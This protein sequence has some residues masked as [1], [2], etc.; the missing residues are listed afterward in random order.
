MTATLTT[1]SKYSSPH[2]LKPK[3]AKGSAVPL[4]ILPL[5]FEILNVEIQYL[6]DLKAHL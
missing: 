6:W 2:L 3:W 1:V 4:P 5:F